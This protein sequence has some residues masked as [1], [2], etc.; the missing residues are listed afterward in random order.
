MVTAP[1]DRMV[2]DQ[3]S[4]KG[5]SLVLHLPGAGEVGEYTPLQELFL[6]LFHLEHLSS[7]KLAFVFPHGS[8]WDS[9][10]RTKVFP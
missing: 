1:R 6:F 8:R 4:W 9:G 10:R 3:L 2:A 7:G 5:T